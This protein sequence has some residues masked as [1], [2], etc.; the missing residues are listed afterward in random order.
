MMKMMRTGDEDMDGSEEHSG[1]NTASRINLL[2]YFLI[3]N[4]SICENNNPSWLQDKQKP[5][6]QYITRVHNAVHRLLCSTNQKV[7]ETKVGG[8]TVLS[9]K[10]FSDKIR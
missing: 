2:F 9:A 1:P 5:Y 6:P 8:R 3:Y 10:E 4:I 7:P